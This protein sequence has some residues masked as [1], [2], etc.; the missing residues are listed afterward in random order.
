MPKKTQTE[1]HIV[2][3]ESNRMKMII[4]LFWEPKLLSKSLSLYFPTNYIIKLF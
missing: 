2:S 4:Q 1:L 3:L